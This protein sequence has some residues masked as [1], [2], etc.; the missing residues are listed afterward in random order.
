MQGKFSLCVNADEDARGFQSVKILFV[1]LVS[2]VVHHFFTTKNTKRTKHT[3]HT[4]HET[5]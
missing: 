4:N 2:F 1:P 5:C 3:K